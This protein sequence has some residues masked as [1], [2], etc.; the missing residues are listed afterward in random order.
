MINKVPPST[1]TKIAY[2]ENQVLKEMRLAMPWLLLEPRWFPV[3]VHQ[4]LD[5]DA[6]SRCLRMQPLMPVR[7]HLDFHG[8]YA[9]MLI[10]CSF[11][12]PDR[13]ALLHARER[14]SFM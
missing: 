14:E 10:L 1:R 5:H 4:A 3:S 7:F 13:R 11:S 2:L 8:E 9:K 12:L 6:P